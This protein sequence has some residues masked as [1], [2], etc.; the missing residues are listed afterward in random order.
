MAMRSVSIPQA[1]RGEVQRRTLPRE[2]IPFVPHKGRPFMLGIS[3]GGAAT[4]KTFN[5]KADRS[6]K[7]AP[8][9]S[10]LYP[11]LFQ[12]LLYIYISAGTSGRKWLEA[13][14]TQ[15]SQDR[16]ALLK[17]S[18]ET[19]RD[20]LTTRLSSVRRYLTWYGQQPLGA[21]DIPWRPLEL[22]VGSHLLH[23]SL[24]GP[25]AA[26]GALAALA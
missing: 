3:S 5:A 15:A 17:R 9:S 23:G 2:P 1:I 21:T 19:F 7:S 24:G 26:S 16:E 25:T 8:S 20:S 22:R 13:P 12:Q 14:T 10:T 11:V 18:I 6:C 4:A